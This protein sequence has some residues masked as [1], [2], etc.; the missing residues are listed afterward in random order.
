M[1]TIIKLL[2]ELFMLLLPVF[3]DNP[4]K[5]ANDVHALIADIKAIKKVEDI[6][7]KRKKAS[8]AAQGLSDLVKRG[9]D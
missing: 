3:K 8:Q 4:E 9:T 7:A 5:F 2:Y 6:N 1:L